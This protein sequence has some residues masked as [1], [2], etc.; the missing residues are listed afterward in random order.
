MLACAE[1]NNGMQGV[2]EINYNKCD[3]NKDIA[4]AG[5]AHYM[6]DTMTL[7]RIS[8]KEIPS[9]IIK[10]SQYLNW[11]QR[12]QHV[13]NAKAIRSIIQDNMDVPT[14][15]EYTFRKKDQVIPLVQN[16]Q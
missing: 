7:L 13:H 12:T 2:T 4:N 1:F 5:Q 9:V 8:M 3:Q 14:G 10:I 16:L 11:S 6:K 15:T